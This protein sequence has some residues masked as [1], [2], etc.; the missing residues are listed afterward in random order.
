MIEEDKETL[1]HL[2]ELMDWARL[3]DLSTDHAF[4][5]FVQAALHLARKTGIKKKTCI[6]LFNLCVEDFYKHFGGKNET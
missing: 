3:K 2:N 1:N 5:L 4:A 6:D